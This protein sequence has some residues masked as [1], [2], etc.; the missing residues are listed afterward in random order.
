MGDGRADLLA[1]AKTWNRAEETV[2]EA[3]ARIH[4]G[5]DDLEKRASILAETVCNHFPIDV[6]P[7]ARIMEVGS[8]TGYIME[9]VNSYLVVRGRAPSVIEGLDIAEH[10][11]AKARR[12][13]GNDPPYA[14][15]HYDGVTIPRPAGVYDL[16]YSV[17]ALQHVP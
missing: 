12:R 17:A 7:G 13:L 14:Y 4:D 9:G 16:I 11:L 3:N 2:E 1:A 15:T 8:G 10:M 6:P 5:A